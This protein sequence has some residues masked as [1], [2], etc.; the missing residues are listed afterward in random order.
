MGPN[1]PLQPPVSTVSHILT[2]RMP[3]NLLFCTMAPVPRIRSS[4][5]E[6]GQTTIITSITGALG[7][8]P[9]PP[10][11]PAPPPAP[12]KQGPKVKH[13]GHSINILGR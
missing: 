7:V 13:F 11:P 9:P 1:L 4:G 2:F 10:P 6:A 3:S 12:P 8:A 5:I